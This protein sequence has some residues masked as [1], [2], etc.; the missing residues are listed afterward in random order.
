M[1]DQIIR[2]FPWG[3]LGACFVAGFLL[4]VVGIV[5]AFK[6]MPYNKK[7]RVRHPESGNYIEIE[8]P[9]L[10]KLKTNLT[11]ITFVFSGL[12]LILVPWLKQ[13]EQTTI[14]PIPYITFEGQVTVS[15]AQN[16]A[17]GVQVAFVPTNYQPHVNSDGTFDLQVPDGFGRYQCIGIFESIAGAKAQVKRMPAIKD[18]PIQLVFSGE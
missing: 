10:G 11:S 1:L 13:P 12:A 3:Y 7:Q 9:A 17:S 15:G 2:F 18:K 8:I 4:T 14:E 5:L 16:A 6:Q